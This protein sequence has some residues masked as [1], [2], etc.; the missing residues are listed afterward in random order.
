MADL[1]L[2]LSPAYTMEWCAEAGIVGCLM[3]IGTGRRRPSK[4]SKVRCG[5]QSRRRTIRMTVSALAFMDIVDYLFGSSR[6]MAV[7]TIRRIGDRRIG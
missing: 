2:A 5:L 3:T 6:V 7:E 1:G 4:L